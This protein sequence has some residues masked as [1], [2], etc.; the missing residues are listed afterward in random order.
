LILDVR[1][2][3][4]QH[5][6][7]RGGLRLRT[8]LVG[9]TTILLIVCAA[10]VYINLAVVSAQTA[11]VQST[12][13]IR[14]FSDS[15]EMIRDLLG[16][17]RGIEAEN[18]ARALLARVESIRGPDALE[19]AE[20]LDLLWRAVVP[21]SKVTDEEKREIVERAVAIKE[22]TLG[23]T[24]PDL[25]TSLINLGVQRTLAGDLAAAKPLLE[26]ALA[27]REAAFGPDHLLV[28]GALHRLGGLAMV[29][30]DDEQAK[31][32]LERAQRIR[33]TA[34][35]AGHYDTIRTLVNLAI[36]YQETGDYTAARQRYE[37]ALGLAE[38]MR[39]STD[40]RTLD[41]LRGVA[42]V[43]S[44][45]GGDFAGA[46]RLNERLL[47]LTERAYGPS[48]L[49]LRAPLE[50]LAIDRRDLGDYAAAK[51][52]AERSLAIAEAALG[53]K[54]AMVAASLHLLATIFAGLGDYAEAMR[55]FER[56][57]GINEEVFRPSNPE[58]ARASWFISD[59][60]PLS[61]YGADDMELFERLLAS[62]EK[63]VGLQNPRTA[64]GLSNLAAV[65]SSDED[66]RRTRPLF[67][68]ALESQE[69]FLGPDHPEVAASATN[70]AYVL[71]RSGDYEAARRLYERALSNWEK[72]LGADHPKVAAALVNLA[73][74]HL[75]TGNYDDAG[76]LLDRALAI[77]EKSLGPEHPDIA[78]TLSSRAELAARTGATSEAFVTAERAEA[79]S[80]EHLR[81]TV[82]T[83]PERQALAYAS[84]LPSALDLML[85]LASTRSGDGQMSTA[86]WNAV[87]RARGM[88]LDEMAAR[89]RSA[90][91]GEG[92]DIGGL[93]EALASARQRLAALTVR[94]VGDDPP[95]RYRRLLERARDEK[96]RTERALAE[97]S[98]KFRDDQSR[99]RILLP[100]VSAA[101]PPD[102]A[103]VG[104]VRYRGQD[105]ERAETITPS[106]PDAEPSYL[107]F[108]LRRGE[109]VPAVVPLG[110]ARRV[111]ALI[112]QWRQQLDHEAIAPRRTS[113]RGEA[114]YRRVAGEL[115]QQVWDP[116]LPQLA[117]AKRV[118]VVPDGALHLVSFAA[119]PTSASHYLVETGP[120]I[121]YLSAER[122]LV[123][124]ETGQ[125]AG[126]GLL[127]LGGPAFDE[128]SLAPVAAEASFRGAR[129]ACSDFQSIRFDP[130]PA[131]EKEVE[132]VVTLWNKAGR[133]R[134]E[135]NQLL[136]SDLSPLDAVR[137]TGVAASE[138]AF[139]AGAPGHRVLHLATHGFFLGG[140]CA[141]ALDPSVK[142]TYAG[143]SAKVTKENPLLLSGLVL[144][145]ANHR[146]RALPDQEDGVL[147][148]E[149]VA[150][151]NLSGVEWA[152][153]SGCDTGA[154]EIRGG[155]GVLGL[156][157]AF[158]E[159]GAK[160]VIMSLWPVE[161]EA[162]RQWMTAL[163]QG[164]LIKKL[165]T[166]DAVREASLAVLRPRRA[167]GLNAH[168][169][170]WGGFVAAGDWR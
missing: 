11:G 166:A 9:I 12:S 23:P 32:L 76:P 30:H 50:N 64:K 105:L 49:R 74:L 127:A 126:E 79:L 137:L 3:R 63:N 142:S 36:L 122:D 123:S 7:L 8:A 167:K 152:V 156:R 147:T 141:S 91:A 48:D 89:H 65:L 94:G 160:T 38:G 83:L 136:A 34:Y 170:Y 132:D 114:A 124:G 47:A 110:S 52:L 121:H 37:R 112:L 59:L 54:H 6:S 103:L 77:Q 157:R 17:G 75:T 96:D 92:K 131:S 80:R 140:R 56:A 5:L 165:S 148:A 104:F 60:F 45:L 84:S 143:A 144:A 100:E 163:Y 86:A 146:N 109:T 90:S 29:L 51:A 16:R 1:S 125:P 58:S 107:A 71:S 106:S 42:V 169:F 82:R 66:F 20:V 4:R 159:A 101:L 113:N 158:Q 161:D 24:H 97:N 72:S 35:G 46:A 57:T 13:P 128:S 154:G 14:G 22:R 120:L 129:S 133:A 78:G 73:R 102:S 27:I 31:V 117:N 149:E 53:P 168:P 88:V 39:G 69:R 130:L 138:S 19:V 61:G 99:S 26:R 87:I 62:R 67:E 68:R 21:S 145:G 153:L 98:A 150:A 81:L 164:R 134:L 115:R 18:V 139:K 95:E 28:A 2:M 85:R 55:L 162:T 43:L 116:L 70:L 25:A 15:L 111:D 119:L 118:F 135:A 41:L 155:E 151:L 93:A 40:L 108:V 33:E 44:E 10:L